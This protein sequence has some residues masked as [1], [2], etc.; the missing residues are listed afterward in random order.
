MKVYRNSFTFKRTICIINTNSVCILEDIL[1]QSIL[2]YEYGIYEKHAFDV[3][4][5]TGT[6]IALITGKTLSYE[7]VCT[8]F[9]Y[10]FLSI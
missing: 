1:I 7:A 3:P 9:V 2:K 10:L 4:L 5:K 6:L 8:H